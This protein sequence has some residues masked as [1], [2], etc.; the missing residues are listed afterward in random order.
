MLLFDRL[1]RTQPHLFSLFSDFHF[2]SNSN[3]RQWFANDN[4][5]NISIIISE[6][7]WILTKVTKV[8]WNF[9]Y[10]IKPIAIQFHHQIM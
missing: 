6:P 4:D 8:D 10:L 7:K 2:D 1:M 9:A 5:A 3:I